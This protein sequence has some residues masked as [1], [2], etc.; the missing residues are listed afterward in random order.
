MSMNKIPESELILNSDLSVYH[1]NLHP[2]EVAGTVIN[3]GDPDR[4]SMVSGF[5]KEIEVKKQKREFVTH[6]GT[7]KGKRITVLSTGI[8]TDNIDIAYNELD[9]LVNIDLEKR[10]IREQ[11]TSLNLIRIGTSGSLQADI[12]VDGFVFSQFGL[13]LDGLLNFYKLKNTEEEQEMID[14]FRKHYP[15]HG[16]LPQ[17]Y[18]V[19]S[20]GKLENALGEGMFKGIT[21]SCSGFY[22]PQGRVLRY[23]LAFPDVIDRLT[24]YQ[25][26]GHRLTNFE[27]ETGAMYGLARILGHHCCS[28]NAIVANRITGQ[29]TYKGEETMY[30]LIETV[31][32]RISAM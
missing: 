13:G 21:A 15:T 20:S 19:R 10:Q 28:I 23:E 14:A 9:A 17:S 26:K 5:F 2:H 4:V 24:A 25:F 8:G 6:T 31:L 11:L 29:H 30:A 27:M 1:L 22:A 7:Y 12:P 18:L 16:V 3:V 32:D